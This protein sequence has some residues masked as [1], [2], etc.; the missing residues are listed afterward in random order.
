V[1]LRFPCPLPLT[2]SR[3]LPKKVWDEKEKGGDLQKDTNMTPIGTGP[4]SVDKVDQTQV[5]LK[6]NDG[7]WGKTVYG[8][9]P[10]PTLAR[11][12]V[13]RSGVVNL[14]EF[15][16]AEYWFAGGR[17]QFV[18]QNQCGKSTLMA[19]TTLIMLAGDLDRKLVDTFGQQHK[20][21]RYYVEPT[22]DDKDRRDTGDSTS[23]GWAWVEYGR[24]VDGHP[25][26]FTALLYTQARRGAN[27]YTKTWATCAGTARVGAGLALHHGASTAAPAD[28]A[29]VPGYAAAGSGTEYKHRLA[30]ALFGFEDADRLTAVVRML[31]VLRTPHLGQRL[32]PAFVTA[33]MREALP[34]IARAEIDGLADGWDELERLAADRDSADSARAAV[35]AYVRKAW[36]PWAD[37]VLRL[38]ADDLLGA[39]TQLDNV[40]RRARDAE[41]ALTRAQDARDKLSGER[42]AADAEQGRVTRA[43]EYMLKSQA[44]RD[45][46][47]ATELVKNLK[48]KAEHE[49]GFAGT[50]E[51]F[52]EAAHDRATERGSELDS[53][54]KDVARA[55]AA[56]ATQVLSTQGAARSAGLPDASDTW[57]DEGDEARLG[58]AVTARRGHVTTATALLS[59]VNK[60]TGLEAGAVR[61][62]RAAEK[63]HAGRAAQA[64]HAT[65][66][67][68]SSLQAVS[69]DLET[70]ALTVG[71]DGPA[72]SLRQDWVAQTS[73][74]S[75]AADPRPVLGA[76]VRT[77]WLD[78][79]IVPLF[80]AAA[81]A[82]SA[83]GADQDR[84][85]ELNRQAALVRAQVDPVPA[86]PTGWTRRARPA[87]DP[88]N[89][90]PLWR[91]LDPVGPLLNGDGNP[92][93]GAL[94]SIEA[95]L[96][97]AGL[98]D[99]WVTPDGVYLPGRDGND[100]ILTTTPAGP[101][102]HGSLTLTAVLAPAAD[103]GACAG[104]VTAF[105]S[106]IG[107]EHAAGPAAAAG[108][109]Y[110]MA[111]DGRWSTPL[112]GG[113][114][115][116]APEGAELIGISA[117]QRARARTLTRLEDESADAA[118]T[119]AAHTRHAGDLREQAGRFVQAAGRAPGDHDVVRTALAVAFC[120]AVPHYVLT[121]NSPSY[122][123]LDPAQ[124]HQVVEGRALDIG[125]RELGAKL[126]PHPD[127]HDRERL[128]A[129]RRERRA[130]RLPGIAR[131]R[132]ARHTA[133][134]R[135][136]NCDGASKAR[137]ELTCPILP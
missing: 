79:V 59:T 72:L 109:G 108:A 137:E 135:Q 28:L 93:A 75:A 39:G 19:L 67:L 10:A 107:W 61:A 83:A 116:P 124:W 17:A 94:D 90:A 50:A 24:L 98:L 127:G 52:A 62:V 85:N 102:A 31:K 57:A 74:A 23:R 71:P 78:P 97:A 66:A 81:L 55:Q 8:A 80:E 105:L 113:K 122:N 95:T 64:T 53:A 51:A 27:D 119:A 37:A 14:W 91:L 117:R 77:T 34:S 21:F 133:V 86:S 110:W 70:W 76:L 126:G 63:E 73:A 125:A 88:E 123:K 45:A 33:Q 54:D 42:D 92:R 20:S 13:L 104:S 11:W 44:F 103:A 22:T 96:A 99:A 2:A 120:V 26:F 41:G 3:I 38:K 58:A 111:H 47:G 118:E 56:A 121:R 6:R 7:Y 129:L 82:E 69:D 128:R 4:Y 136:A 134:R 36:A 32:D 12:Q 29:A 15:D 115:S 130:G 87:A 35:A 89:G 48:A 40:T 100:T 60:A 25:D 131:R 65:A 84:A 101:G 5:V 114:A 106:S 30:T 18:G 68:G 1:P 9:L 46:Q 49:D 112:T 43:Y 132:P 16:V